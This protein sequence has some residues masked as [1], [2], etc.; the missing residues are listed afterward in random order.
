MMGRAPRTSAVVL[1]ATA[2]TLLKL[3]IDAAR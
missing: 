2:V 3:A 1:A